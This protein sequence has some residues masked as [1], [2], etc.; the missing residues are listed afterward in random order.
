MVCEP[1]TLEA[2]LQTINVIPTNEDLN[3]HKVISKAAKLLSLCG[4]PVNAT[5]VSNVVTLLKEAGDDV[6]E[7]LYV[8]YLVGAEWH[9]SSERLNSTQFMQ[10]VR[11]EFNRIDAE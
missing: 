8:A 10:D 3:M 5:T 7:L 2:S 1:N 9:V 6:D 11:D 4:A